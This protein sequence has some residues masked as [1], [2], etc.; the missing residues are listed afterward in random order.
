MRVVARASRLG[1]ALCAGAAVCVSAAAAPAQVTLA[2][3]ESSTVKPVIQGLIDRHGPP[4]ANM[5]GTVDA[6]VVAVNWSD[7]QPTAFGPIVE[8]NAIDEAITRVRQPDFAAVGMT[9]KIRVFAGINAPDWAKNLGGAPVPFEDTQ[10]GEVTPPGT[11]IGR[12]WT[13][14][15]GAAYDDVENKLAALYDT[16][17]EIREVTVSRCSTIYDELFVRELSDKNNAA[18]L[19][20]A[21]YTTEAD[22]QC[23]DDA[24]SEHD[25]WQHT[26]SDIDVSPFPTPS[27]PTGSHDLPFTTSM[28]SWCRDQLGI[29]CGLENNALSAGKL[30]NALFQQLYAAMT[31][32]GPPITLQTS[33]ITRM[34]RSQVVLPAGV[35]IGA[36]SI[37]LPAGFVNFPKTVLQAANQNLIANPLPGA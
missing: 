6:Y 10:A 13:P 4:P 1:I 7:I 36:N 3:T 24:I 26:T 22:K 34:G 21:G 14:E 20:A 17:P 25:V 32:L 35:Q 33:V 19:K 18:A 2:A 30:K 28:M 12:F 23:I 11:T 27:D 15:F 9:L 29:R 31:A 37:E 16:V 8:G 5:L